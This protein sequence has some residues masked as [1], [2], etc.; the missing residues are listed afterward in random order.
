MSRSLTG[1]CA[2]FLALSAAIPAAAQIQQLPA[3]SRS[4]AQVNSL[5]RDMTRDQEVRGIVQQNQ[6]ESNQIRQQIT[7]QPTITA[8]PIAL[9]PNVGR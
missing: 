9:P 5:N 1:A 3:Q 2:L 4:E 6:F 8:P 7:T